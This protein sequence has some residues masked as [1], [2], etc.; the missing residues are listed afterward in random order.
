MTVTLTKY[1]TALLNKIGSYVCQAVIYIQQQQP[2]LLLDKYKS[3]SWVDNSNQS[4]LKTKLIEAIGSAD[5]WES[6]IARMEVFIKALLVPSATNTPVLIKLQEK[7]RQF[8]PNLSES[9]TSDHQKKSNIQTTSEEE[10]SPNQQDINTPIESL[11][12][13]NELKISENQQ[14]INLTTKQVTDT[15]DN[16][17]Q[18]GIA[19]LLL[20][21]ENIQIT[22]ETEQFLTTVCHH[23]IQIK[24][25]FANWQSMGKK[26]IE[27]HQRG[28]DLIHVPR[29][30]DNA[31]G[32]MIAF[33]STI[34]QHYPKVK[35]VLVCSSDT[36]MTNLCNH[37]QQKGLTVYQVSQK[38]SNLTVFNSKTNET[39]THTIFP[40]IEQLLSQIKDIV[41]Q[42]V[43]QT[44]NQWVKLS[45][46][47]KIFKEKYSFSV[48]KVVSHHLPGKNVKNIFINKPEFVIHQISEH[49]EVYITLFKMPTDEN[50][51]HQILT[52]ENKSSLEQAI[53][54]IITQLVGTTPNNYIPIHT[55]GERFNKQYGKGITKILKELSLTRNFV[56]FLQS[57]NFVE[58]KKTGNIWQVA[59]R[60]RN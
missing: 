11:P 24:T 2:E 10:Q 14:D 40:S 18:T 19:V 8:N 33:G 12:P 16:Q 60:V 29:G 48:N 17:Q 41:T 57:C 52:F 45:Q 26:D 42:Q 54:R 20:D 58:L 3:I 5:D 49:P 32:K 53:V 55:V 15:P 56:N 28:Y 27:F 50:P 36:V 37:L 31:D 7:I 46:I 22:P 23:D 30:K 43:A 21:A 9:K 59:L 39:Q 38:E 35:E 4:R 47:C 13:T 1:P 6:L 51:D 34:D 25:A 44:S